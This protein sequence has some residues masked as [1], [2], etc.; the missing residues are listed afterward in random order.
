MDSTGAVLGMLLPKPVNPAKRLPADVN[1]AADA[2]AITAALAARGISATASTRRGGM[3]P[4]DLGTLA[5]NM[6]VLVS[7]WK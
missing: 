1:F 3:A 7:C 2:G 6:T 5:A 4:E